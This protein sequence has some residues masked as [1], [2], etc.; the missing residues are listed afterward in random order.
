MVTVQSYN[1]PPTCYATVYIIGTIL[2]LI[3]AYFSLLL[4]LSVVI[5]EILT[6]PIRSSASSSAGFCLLFDSVVASRLTG[7]SLE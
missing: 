5:A 4:L 7:A 1:P 2:Y 3:E 6:G